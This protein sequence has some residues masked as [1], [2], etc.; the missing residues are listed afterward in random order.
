MPKEVA[1]GCA[2]KPKA[3]AAVAQPDIAPAQEHPKE[4]RTMVMVGQKA[5][6]F[7][8][9]AYHNGK[10]I[11]TSLSDYQGKWVH[12]CFYPGDFTFV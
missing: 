2:V 11:E 3:K 5:P 8:T 7:T 4:E 10:F 1:V 6:D 9:G 12:L